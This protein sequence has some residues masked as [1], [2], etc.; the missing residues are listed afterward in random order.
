MTRDSAIARLRR[1][2]AART[3][4]GQCTCR[5]VAEQ[6]LFCHGFRRDDHIELRMRYAAVI[7]VTGRRPAVE[8]RANEYQLRRVREEGA[9]VACDV[10]Q[11]TYEICGGWDEFTNE[12]LAQFYFELI[13]E[14]VVV[15]RN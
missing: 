4:E 7:D 15:V 9:A 12:Q 5:F 6:N 14:H 8:D 3:P 13:G 2:L 1:A 10:Q 11:H